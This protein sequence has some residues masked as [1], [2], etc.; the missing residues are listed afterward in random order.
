MLTF[1]FFFIAKR[2]QVAQEASFFGAGSIIPPAYLDT[3]VD[4]VLFSQQQLQPCAEK[5]AGRVIV[6]GD[7]FRNANN[8]NII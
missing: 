5:T 7:P 1:P 6:K 4:I 3:A 2:R 8:L